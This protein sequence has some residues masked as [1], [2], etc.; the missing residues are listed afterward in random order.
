LNFNV[1]TIDMHIIILL[2]FLRV[3][4]QC[5]YVDSHRRLGITFLR[6]DRAFIQFRTEFALRRTIST[7]SA[8]GTSEIV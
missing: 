4:T 2:L 7:Y 6:N 5:G 8:M 3:I 1:K